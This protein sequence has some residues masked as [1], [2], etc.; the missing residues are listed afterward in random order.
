MW[1]SNA[2]R[3]RRDSRGRSSWQRTAAAWAVLTAQGRG[4]WLSDCKFGVAWPLKATMSS[5]RDTHTHS[6]SPRAQRR[7]LGGCGGG[8]GGDGAV[9]GAE[10]G[11]RQRQEDKLQA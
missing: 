3:R 1:L 4:L 10:G 8:E 11:G 7:K 6:L 5:L 9:G 2:L